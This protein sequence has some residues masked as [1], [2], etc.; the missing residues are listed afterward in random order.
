[1]EEQ[2]C[3]VLLA[4]VACGEFGSCSEI[5][6]STLEGFRRSSWRLSTSPTGHFVVRAACQFWSLLCALGSQGPGVRHACRLLS[7]RI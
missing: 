3:A 1:M 4:I 6:Q 2:L 7:A 5:G